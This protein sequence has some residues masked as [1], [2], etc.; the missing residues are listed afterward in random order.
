[1]TVASA[2]LYVFFGW[3]SDRVGRKPVMLGGML[4]ALVAYFPGFHAMAEA[5][6]PAL[7]AAQR[8]KPVVVYTNPST[9]SVQFDPIG[10][11]QFKSACDIAK[12]LLAGTGIS[13][14][15]ASAS[16]G[17]TIVAVG[18]PGRRSRP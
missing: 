2:P 6:N 4:L 11:H 15:N 14:R 8:A 5:A 12:S 9:C 17:R 16:N 10:T 13:Y 3:L 18:L 1:M 7:V